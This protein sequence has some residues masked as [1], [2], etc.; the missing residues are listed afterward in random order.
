MWTTSPPACFILNRI[1]LFFLAALVVLPGLLWAQEISVNEARF[2]PGDHPDWAAAA[3]DDSSWQVLSLDK[4]WDYQGV[5]NPDNF[6]WYRIHVRIPLSIKK[7]LPFPGKILLN[8]GCIDDCDETWL[9]GM[10]IWSRPLSD[11][12]IA[13]GI[14]NMNEA[15]VPV[16]LSGA[17]AKIGLEAST[18]RDLW[19]QK[20]IPTEEIYII[21]AHG[22]R[23][24]KVK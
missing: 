6:A 11:G 17:L 8:L 20:V 2:H 5:S 19:R 9:N 12:G 3:Y 15:P 10:Q 21:P 1:R 13:V 16:L 24:V 18:V 22:V 23:Y 14:F 4:E 7:R